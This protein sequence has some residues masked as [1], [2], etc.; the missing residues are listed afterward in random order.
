MTFAFI[1]GKIYKI[2]NHT[3]LNLKSDGHK[4]HLLQSSCKT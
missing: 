3:I 4:G 2:S 1:Y